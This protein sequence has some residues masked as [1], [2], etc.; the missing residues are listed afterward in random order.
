MIKYC[1]LKNE[2]IDGQDFFKVVQP[3]FQRY[4]TYMYITW[5]SGGGPELEGAPIMIT[6]SP[7]RTCLI[8]PFPVIKINEMFF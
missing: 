5:I 4:T 1:N 3:K 8:V 7:D 2:I 6:V